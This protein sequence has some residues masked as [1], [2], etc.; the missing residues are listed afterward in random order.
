[1]IV[2]NENFNEND[3]IYIALG[4]FDGLHKGHMSLIKKV[5]QLAKANGGKSMVYTF[6]DHPLNTIDPKFAP[7]LIMD[8]DTKLNLLVESDIDFV[9]LQT[10]D[11]KF[12]K[13]SPEN[14]IISI[15]KRFNIK[16]MVVGFNY[17][18]GYKNQGDVDLLFNLSKKYNF[19]LTV[20]NPFKDEHTIISST[21]IRQLIKEGKIKKANSYLSMPFMIKGNVVRGKGLGETIGYPT[22]NIDYDKR[23]V[24]PGEGVYYT[25]VKYNETFYRGITSIG[26]NPTVYGEKLTIETYILDFNE[27]I[28]GKEIHLCFIEKTREQIKFP[29]VEDLVEQLK[30]DEKSAKMKKIY[31]N[32]DKNNLQ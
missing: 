11:D 27:N 6:K 12:M 19:N 31:I 4:S 18:F 10:F 29:T 21:L 32:L 2:I 28:Y 3:D 5:S 14:F 17:R 25:N 26:F 7:K 9:L 20:M 23:Y 30:L 15:C 8:N 1:M 24:L 16:G 22:A 13:L